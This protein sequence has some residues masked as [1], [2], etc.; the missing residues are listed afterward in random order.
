GSAVAH[1]RYVRIESCLDVRESDLSARV[2]IRPLER[3]VSYLFPT[4]LADGV[5]RAIRELTIVGDCAG[6][7]DVFAHVRAVDRRRDEM[8]LATG[9]EQ[10]CRSGGIGVVELRCP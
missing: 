3:E 1:E 4:R 8:I 7:L 10:Q 5:M 6:F 9:Y 2:V